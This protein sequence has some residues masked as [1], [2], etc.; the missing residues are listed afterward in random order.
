LCPFSSPSPLSSVRL[1]PRRPWLYLHPALLNP[2]LGLADGVAETPS[3][4]ETSSEFH[5]PVD[6]RES[7]KEQWVAEH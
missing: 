3:E 5:I 1:R 7:I 2:L 6:V 4:F